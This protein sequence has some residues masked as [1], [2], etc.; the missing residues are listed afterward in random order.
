MRCHLG[1]IVHG[2]T[3]GSENAGQAT[4]SSHKPHPLG[5]PPYMLGKGV[6][7]TSGRVAQASGQLLP[8]LLLLQSTVALKGSHV[9][10][11]SEHHARP[12]PPRE[13]TTVHQERLSFVLAPLHLSNFFEHASFAR[14]P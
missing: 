7:K 14:G 13:G 2:R 4:P 3:G 9:V 1:G 11:A 10:S 5:T 12:P 8:T 6:A